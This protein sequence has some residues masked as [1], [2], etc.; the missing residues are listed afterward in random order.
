MKRVLLF[1][2]LLWM[3]TTGFGQQVE[4]V[5]K[6]SGDSSQKAKES[7]RDTKEEDSESVIPEKATKTPIRKKKKLPRKKI[8]SSSPTRVKHS[9]GV[10]QAKKLKVHRPVFTQKK[11]KPYHG[12]PSH[13]VHYYTPMQ[14]HYLVPPMY[15]YR[16]LWIR[17]WVDHPDGFYMYNGYPYYVWN[18]YLH[19]YSAT[20]EG[21]Y[22]VVDSYTD[23]VYATF[24]GANIQQSY[25]RAAEMRDILNYR[26]KSNRYFCAERFEYNPD[27]HYDWDPDD[28]PDWLWE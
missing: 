24:Y 26:E 15:L 16:G 13:H 20:D 27:H 6:V 18:G 8:Y 23:E 12:T 21:S 19:R 3:C 9:E 22:D 11:H 7:I 1:T 4:K 28:Y 17:W 14:Y 2:L 25:D 5:N 10:H